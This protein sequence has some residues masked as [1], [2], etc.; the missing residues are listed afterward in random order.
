MRILF[1]TMQERTYTL[2]Y[3]VVFV[4]LRLHKKSSRCLQIHPR[5]GN[6]IWYHLYAVIVDL[7]TY[8]DSVNVVEITSIMISSV[9]K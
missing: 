2:F 5:E 6:V 7:T 1:S 9:C 3:G 8:T 4:R